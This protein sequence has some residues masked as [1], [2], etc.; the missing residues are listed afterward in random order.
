MTKSRRGILKCCCPSALLRCNLREVFRDLE[1][2]QK[3][4]LT[5]EVKTNPI[6]NFTGITLDI[7]YC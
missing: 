3:E 7:V 6:N 2:L 1:I 4:L 5:G